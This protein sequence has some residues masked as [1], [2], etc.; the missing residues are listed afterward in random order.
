MILRKIELN[1]FRNYTKETIEFDNKI[2]IFLGNNAQGKTNI[3]ESIYTLAIT[4]SHRILLDSDLIKR[5]TTFF[6]IK[7][8]IENKQ[9]KITLEILYRNLKKTAKVNGNEIKKLN[10]YISILN[11]IM[12]CPDDLSIIKGAP[13][14]RRN[15]L[16]I[17]LGQMSKKYILILSEYKKILKMRNEYLKKIEKKENKDTKY[18]DIIT[19]ELIKRA[20]KI[21]I[22]RDKFIKDINKD[23]NEIYKNITNEGNLKIEYKTIPTKLNISENMGEELKTIFKENYEK[24]ILQGKTLYGPHKDEIIFK[25]NNEDLKML[26]SQGQQRAAIISL[27][28]SEISIFKE[29]TGNY[30][31]LLLDDIFSELDSVKINNLLDYINGEYQTIIT[32]TDLSKIEKRILNKAT[33]F[34]IEDGKVKKTRGDINERNTL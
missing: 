21:Y 29:V 27:K 19:D 17:Q 24:E 25:L 26:G 16:N 20:I 8:E 2:N 15:Y 5:G 6:K 12:F 13:N 18:L 1:N 32:T 14:I 34:E 23:I 3:L 4:K 11:V 33:F 10:E 31:I 28:I 30:P 22:M 7:G 9:D